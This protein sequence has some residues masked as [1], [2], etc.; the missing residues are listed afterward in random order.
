MC[1]GRG[2][3]GRLHRGRGLAAGVPGP[4]GPLDRGGARH[5]GRRLRLRHA[6]GLR[7]GRQL[8]QLDQCQLGAVYHVDYLNIYTNLCHK[9]IIKIYYNILFKI[10]YLGRRPIQ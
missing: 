10:Q 7:Q 9:I 6:R 1:G 8:H 4:V 2:G 5:L 3:Q